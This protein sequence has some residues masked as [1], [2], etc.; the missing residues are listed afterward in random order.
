MPSVRARHLAALVLLSVAAAGCANGLFSDRDRLK[1]A[2]EEYH[3]GL[4]WGKVEA[5][6]AHL[7]VAERLRFAERFQ[8]L[9][10]DLEV[11]DYEVQRIEWDR[12]RGIANVRVDVSRSLKRRGI[13]ERSVLEQRWQEVGGGWLIARQ[14]RIAGAALPLLDEEPVKTAPVSSAPSSR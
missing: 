5:S 1:M 3:D 6:A 9:Q 8:Q 14:R 10:G 11:M 7:P 4:R 12:P 13:V 2:L